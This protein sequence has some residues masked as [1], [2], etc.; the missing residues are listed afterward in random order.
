M[1]SCDPIAFP[2][3]IHSLPDHL[4]AH[5]FCEQK[6]LMHKV[7]SLV[8][9]YLTFIIPP[10]LFPLIAY[11]FPRLIQFAATTLP[12]HFSTVIEQRLRDIDEKLNRLA[13]EILNP[14][15]T[16]SIFLDVDGVLYRE[17]PSLKWCLEAKIKELFPDHDF[18]Q[19]DK[20]QTELVYRT[21]QAYFFDAQALH[22]LNLLIS[23]IEKFA[24]IQ[25]ILSS[26]WRK[27]RSLETLKH[28]F[29]HHKFSQYLIDKTT[30]EVPLRELNSYCSLDNHFIPYSSC[31]ASEIHYWLKRHPEVVNYLI[32]DDQDDHLSSI[33]GKRF[34]RTHDA[35]LLTLENVFQ[36]LT[37]VVED[38]FINA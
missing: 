32:L 20:I 30:D 35:D 4:F 21:V 15:P 11:H 3:C 28:L 25:I 7:T 18:F 2:P 31:R 12:H 22:H 29:R 5:P 17:N 14:K 6:P 19:A 27:N 37:N 33:F 8:L 26:N 9:Y 36:A 13:L 23:K 10:R 1:V 16:V 24:H 34:I 38:Q